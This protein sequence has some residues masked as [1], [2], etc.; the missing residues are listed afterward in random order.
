MSKLIHEELSGTIIGSPTEGLAEFRPGRELALL[1][2]FKSAKSEW[3]RFLPQ[4]KQESI[5]RI[6]VI[7][8]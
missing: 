1:L 7:S 4:H 3:K 8:A 2:N 5:L 6:S